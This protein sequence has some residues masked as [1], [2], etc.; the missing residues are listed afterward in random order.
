MK[1]VWDVSPNSYMPIAPPEEGQNA[2]FVRFSSKK[3][4]RTLYGLSLGTAVVEWATNGIW[5]R[6]GR[7]RVLCCSFQFNGK[8]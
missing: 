4:T 2:A 6:K 5:A 7:G 8:L 3:R 1:S